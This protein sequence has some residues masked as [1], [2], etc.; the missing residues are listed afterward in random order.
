MSAGRSDRFSAAMAI[1]NLILRPLTTLVLYRLYVERANATGATVPTIFGEYFY[2]ITRYY[3]L[4]VCCLMSFFPVCGTD[5]LVAFAGVGTQQRAP[6]EDI[7]G[8][9]HQ[10]VPTNVPSPSNKVPPP[11]H[12]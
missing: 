12:A 7:G 8:T 10:S 2:Y 4:A 9:V 6:Y 3:S 5:I 1:L 11:Y